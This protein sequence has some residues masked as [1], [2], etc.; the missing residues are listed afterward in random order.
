M[1]TE[2]EVKQIDIIVAQLKCLKSNL[3]KV[4]KLSEKSFN[5]TTSNNSPKQIQKAATDLNFACME[6]DKQRKRTW[7]SIK[8]AAFLEVSLEKTEYH[9]S[10][11]HIYN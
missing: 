6:L 8:D 2:E 5:M 1:K 9:L 4:D 3:Q 11:F 10:P 7:K